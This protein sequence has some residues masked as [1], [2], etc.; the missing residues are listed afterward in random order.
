M[1]K[2]G[3]FKRFEEKLKCQCGKQGHIK[4]VCSQS[5]PRNNVFYKNNPFGMPIFSG[6]CG[7]W[8]TKCRTMS[9]IHYIKYKYKIANTNI[10][11]KYK[12]IK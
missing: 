7:R 12:Y 6:L 4:R 10:Y 11:I 1:D 3:D 8:T 2:R 9:N 5:I